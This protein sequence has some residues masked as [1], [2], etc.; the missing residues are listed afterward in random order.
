MTVADSDTDASVAPS[1]EPVVWWRR[2][3]VVAGAFITAIV[4]PFTVA[5][6]QLRNPRPYVVLDLA[7]TEMRVRSVFST[8]PPL[9]GLP[10]RL[11]EFGV[12]TGSH[13]GPLSFWLLAPFYKLFGSTPWALFAGAFILNFAWICVALW[14]G[15]RRGRLAMLIGVGAIV[16]F[17]VQGFGIIVVEQ[18]WNPYLPLM[19]WTV[20]LLA[21]WSVLVDDIE[22]LPVLVVA[23]SYCMQTHLP[24]L[25][26]GGGM[27]V[28]TVVLVVLWRHHRHR[29]DPTDD[30]E[31]AERWSERRLAWLMGDPQRWPSV[32]RT[33]TWIGI[34]AAVG[35]VLW[36]APIFEQFHSNQGNL[37]LIWEDLVDPPQA[38][39]GLSQGIH[40]ILAHL[41]PWQLL[42]GTDIEFVVINSN[43]PGGIFLAVWALGFVAAWRFRMRTLV[44]GNVVITLSLGFALLALSSIYGDLYWYLMMWMWTIC[45]AMVASLV[46]VAVEAVRRS[47]LPAT[48]VRVLRS[49]SAGVLAVGLVVMFAG[50]MTQ[51]VDAEIPDKNLSR[52]MSNVVPD[53]VAAIEAGQVP[54]D[55]GE[56][57]YLVTWFDPVKIGSGGY[58]LLDELRG[59]GIDAGLRPAFLGIVPG[60]LTIPEG[61][62]RGRVHLAVGDTNIELWRS[63]VDAVEVAYY[64]G[65]TP[66]ERAEFDRLRAKAR[67]IVAEAGGDPDVVDESLTGASLNTTLPLEATQA[68]SRMSDI[69]LPIAVFLAPPWTP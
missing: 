3:G 21:A 13:P 5:A 60:R 44:I 63:N 1:Q 11:G 4:V 62:E 43:W 52:Q 66:A 16:L 31:R 37:T 58:T 22:M 32:K 35:L 53:T 10:G 68:M 17:L 14:L 34:A 45:A 19:A 15:W 26:M 8:N 59:H 64:D 18:P 40:L 38:A 24:Y 57:M 9:I 46:W 23:A 33:W 54:G 50:L 42:A 29:V 25:G 61:T 12:H 30:P 36:A 2:P 39:G 69:G 20:V 41:Q 56:G 51:A 27:V 28:A 49:G 65:R 67:R 48:T 47:S 55:T 7:Q 6:M